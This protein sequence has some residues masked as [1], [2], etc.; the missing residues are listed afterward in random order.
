MNLLPRFFCFFLSPRGVFCC[1]A[2]SMEGGFLYRRWWGF[3]LMG[4]FDARRVY[5]KRGFCFVGVWGLYGISDA[6]GLF[7]FSTTRMIERTAAGWGF[8]SSMMGDFCWWASSMQGWFSLRERFLLCGVWGF[9][10]ISDARGFFVVFNYENDRGG[11]PHP[12]LKLPSGKGGWF[13]K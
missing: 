10:G 3:L 2:S 7:V 5:S 4:I 13:R 12:P 6:R 1:R 8:I 9:V 11:P